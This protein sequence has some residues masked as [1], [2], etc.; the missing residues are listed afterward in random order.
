MLTPIERVPPGYDWHYVM[1][2][3]DINLQLVPLE[4]EN[5]YR[6][7]GHAPGWTDPFEVQ[8]LL[9]RNP[10]DAKQY[11]VIGRTEDILVLSTGEKV[12][13]TNIERAV[14][15]HPRINAA[16]A[17]GD[18]QVALGLLIELADTRSQTESE[19][20]DAF[21]A[22]ILPDL[23]EHRNMSPDMIIMTR[24]TTKPFQ[25]TDKGTT[26]RKATLAAFDPEIKACYARRSDSKAPLFPLPPVDN[27]HAT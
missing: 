19:D 9:E 22:L 1:P 20:M 10:L 17:F 16:L 21:K 15:E 12:R 6:L 2:R 11:R 18:G 3:T 25:R 7:I 8:D 5:G 26:A 23:N 24:E 4:G 27:D 13:P 14:S